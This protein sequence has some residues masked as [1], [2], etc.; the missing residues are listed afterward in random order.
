MSDLEASKVGRVVPN[1]WDRLAAQV[2]VV[3]AA[4]DFT[5][6]RF[7]DEERRVNTTARFLHVETALRDAVEAYDA[8]TS[9][10]SG[11]LPD[12]QV[13]PPEEEK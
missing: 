8:F 2:R 5:Q 3:N 4:R 6:F 1:G 7:T 11:A 9:G 12:S 10:D 13:A